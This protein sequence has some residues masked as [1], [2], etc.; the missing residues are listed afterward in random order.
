M[1]EAADREREDKIK[2]SETSDGGR[3]ED[4]D[5]LVAGTR[6]RGGIG[7]PERLSGVGSRGGRA[8]GIGS[9]SFLGCCCLPVGGE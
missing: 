1:E 8:T 4:P 2:S 9:R 7:S 5:G 6:N 3:D